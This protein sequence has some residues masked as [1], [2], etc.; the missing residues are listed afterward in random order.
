[1]FDMFDKC[2]ARYT[3]C[4]CDRPYVVFPRV[5]SLQLGLEFGWS[6]VVSCIQA[7]AS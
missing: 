4:L 2:H 7:S 6:S 5:W 1:M 3:A